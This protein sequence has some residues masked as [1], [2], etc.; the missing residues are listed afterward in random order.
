MILLVSYNKCFVILALEKPNC[1]VE[2]LN[3]L[4]NLKDY[5][6]LVVVVPS[7]IESLLSISQSFVKY[8]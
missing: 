7:V 5:G 1:L 4:T 6:L 3:Q 8:A 2:W